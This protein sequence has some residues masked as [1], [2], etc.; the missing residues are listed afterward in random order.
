M[1]ITVGLENTCRT[2]VT[3]ANTALA[4]GSG[5]LEVF[6]T[7]AMVAL[8][9][10]AAWKSIAPFLSE[11][12]SSVGT[13]ITLSHTAPTPFGE[14]VWAESTVTAVEGRRVEFSIVAYD[15]KGEIGKAT[16]QRAIIHV[17]K[18]MSKAQN[19]SN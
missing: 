1:S 18:F 6:A 11:E 12:E 5:V 15:N 4:M 16:H 19:K 9:E 14:A 13:G 10:E 8:M 7:P 3:S 2:T 17:A